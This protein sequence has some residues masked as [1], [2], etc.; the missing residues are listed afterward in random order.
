[1]ARRP[2]WLPGGG[3]GSI[4]LFLILLILVAVLIFWARSRHPPGRSHPAATG[5]PPTL[6]ARALPAPR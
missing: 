4:F 3:G 2:A 5:V 1:M 6:P